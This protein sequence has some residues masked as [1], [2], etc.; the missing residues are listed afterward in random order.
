M[1]DILASMG[2]MELGRCV[3]TFSVLLFRGG[4]RIGAGDDEIEWR[5]A[6]R[7]GCY[8]IAFGCFIGADLYLFGDTFFLVVLAIIGWPW[9]FS[10]KCMYRRSCV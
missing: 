7:V 3:S 6:H 1:Y 2:S 10:L 5:F 4:E 8:W 9:K